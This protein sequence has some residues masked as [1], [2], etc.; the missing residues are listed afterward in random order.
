MK[1]LSSMIVLATVSVSSASIITISSSA[2]TTDLIEHNESANNRSVRVV[3]DGTSSALLHQTFKHENDFTMEKVTFR[4]SSYEAPYAF[5]GV[6]DQLRLYVHEDTNNDG[7]P[8]LIKYQRDFNLTATTWNPYRYLTF[9]PD[10]GGWDLDANVTYS[11]GLRWMAEGDDHD[12]RLF[13]GE[14]GN[15]A[16]G[17]SYTGGSLYGAPGDYDMTFYIQGVPEPASIGL[18]AFSAVGLVFARRISRV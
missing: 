16:D 11:V 9:D 13:Q 14:P 5:D 18:L 17:G 1:L 10:V 8:D 15:Y 2:P 6:N 7:T 3:R 4:V 12:L